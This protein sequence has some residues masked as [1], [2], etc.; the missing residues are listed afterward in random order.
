MFVC[1]LCFLLIRYMPIVGYMREYDLVSTKFRLPNEYFRYR[2]KF[3]NVKMKEEGRASASRHEAVSE[4]AK[5][6]ERR[7]TTSTG[8]GKGATARG[9]ARE[10]TKAG[11]AGKTG[12]GTSR[13]HATRDAQDVLKTRD[14]EAVLED[15]NE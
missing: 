3:T 11:E 7:A 14:L 2:G 5:P 15:L 9:E 1:D 4:S 6:T 8:G 13:Q 10:G 12:N